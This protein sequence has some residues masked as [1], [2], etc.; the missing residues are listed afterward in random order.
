MLP[1]SPSGSPSSE[2]VLEQS[3]GGGACVLS[4]HGPSAPVRGAGAGARSA[5]L[6]LI[7]EHLTDGIAEFEAG[8]G[9]RQG[10]GAGRLVKN[11]AFPVEWEGPGA[12]GFAQVLKIQPF[13]AGGYEAT[14]RP[15][16]LTRIG[17]AIEFG[18]CRGKREAPEE[19]RSES[20]EKSA[21]RAR[22]KVRHLVKNMGATHLAT[23]TRREGVGGEFWTPEQWGAA[24]DRLRR[25]VE[26]VLGKF[27]YVGILERHQKGNFHLHVAW[28][29]RINL[30]VI[31][32]LW[33]SICGGRGQGNVDAQYIKVR[34]GLERSDRVARY[35]S[36]YVSKMFEEAGRFNKKRYWAS[37]QTMD[38]VRRYVLRAGTMQGALDEV[39]RMLGLD[40]G[41]FLVMKRGRLV[42]EH[43]FA[44]PDG[45]GVWFNFIPELHGG[46]PP[47]F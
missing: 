9:F 46:A 37:R 6:D 43:L 45:T 4:G 14:I 35:I 30:N 25:G 44:F 24:W 10:F 16:N 3:R 15:L 38:E 42:P 7:K 19:V 34:E 26:R 32:P 21:A 28:V 1:T 5:P 2:G 23:F 39:K 13:Q 11:W 20:V 17:N 22:R 12:D 31:R 41:L 8:Q 29:G 40:W 27:P 47:P 18:G 33:W 36:K